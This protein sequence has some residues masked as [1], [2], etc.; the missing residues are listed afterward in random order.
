MG[1]GDGIGKQS[2][3]LKN[4]N[5]FVYQKSLP[6]KGRFSGRFSLRIV[7][8]GLK[9]IDLLSVHLDFRELFWNCRKMYQ[10]VKWPSP[11][12]PSHIMSVWHTYNWWTNVGTLLTVY[13]TAPAALALLHNV[14]DG[15]TASE[16]LH[17]LRSLLG[18]PAHAVTGSYGKPCSAPSY[19][20]C[21]TV[22][23]QVLNC[24]G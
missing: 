23:W 2:D 6:P 10:A 17:C 7:I 13:V 5:V 15:L 12:L 16:E 1:K 14:T 21:Q 3:N 24:L 8:S 22:L 18:S 19:T 4:S 9:R 11:V 20:N